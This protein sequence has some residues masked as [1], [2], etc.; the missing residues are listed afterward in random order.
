MQHVQW[1]PGGH[2]NLSGPARNSAKSVVWMAWFG[3]AMNLWSDGRPR[4]LQT[5]HWFRKP[6]RMALVEGGYKVEAARNSQDDI[7]IKRM[8]GRQ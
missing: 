7:V 8:Q 3:N 1:I 4:N 6:S 2:W 5:E